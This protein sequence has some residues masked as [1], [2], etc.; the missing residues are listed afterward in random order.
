MEYA[1]PPPQQP[2]QY[3]AEQVEN[4]RRQRIRKVKQHFGMRLG[5]EVL[6]TAILAGLLGYYIHR[7][8]NNTRT[9]S[10]WFSWYIG[11]LIGLL[12]LDVLSIAFTVWQM[13]QRLSWLKDPQTPPQLIMDGGYSKIVIFQQP[14]EYPAPNYASQQGA[15]AYYQ[16]GYGANNM[17]MPPSSAPPV[18][19]LS[20]NPYAP[21]KSAY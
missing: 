19:P 15:P 14:Q 11:L 16:Q 18:Q 5:L 20:G 3:T 9:Y 4:V 21:E 12:V 13:K 6:F 8:Q 10:S 2:V 17:Y 7:E 1:Y